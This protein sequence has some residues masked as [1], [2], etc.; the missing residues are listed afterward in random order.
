MSSVPVQFLIYVM[1]EP[2]CTLAPIIMPLTGCLEV[3]VGVPV[4]LNLTIVNRCDPSAVDI[5]DLVLA[6]NIGGMTKGTL[7]SSSTNKSLSYVGLAWTPL[8]S[9]IG[10]QQLCAVAY[11]E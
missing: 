11:T 10:P 7:T 3:S 9:Q 8:A 2:D 1:P 5:S 4:A 6:K